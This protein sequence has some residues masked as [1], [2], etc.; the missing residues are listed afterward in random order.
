[1][2]RHR[3]RVIGLIMIGILTAGALVGGGWWLGQRSQTQSAAS[4]VTTAPSAGPPA[5]DTTTPATPTSPADAGTWQR[6]PAAPI[7]GGS[8]AGVWTGTELL[9]HAP[10]FDHQN[11]SYI[12][13]SVGAAY[14]PATHSWRNLPPAP[15]PVES[16]EGGYRAVW[17][18]R[19]LLGW[20]MGL[21][22]AYNPATNRWRKIATGGSAWAVMAWTG[23]QVLTWGGGCCGDD[24]AGGAAYNPSTDSWSR[25]PAGPLAGRQQTTG[26][27]TGTELVVV[28]G[29]NVDA[30]VFG[31]AAAYN[32]ATR[33]WRRLPALPEPRTG[34]T[35][36]WNGRE[37]LVVGGQGRF[38]DRARPYADGV[39]YSPASNRWRRLPAMDTGRIG[40]TA[41][42][43]GRQLLVWGGRTRDAGSW[44]APAHGLAYDRA[45][46]R[47]SPL[48]KS[49]LRGRAGHIAVWTGSQMLVW[50]GTPA[51]AS[52]PQKPFADGAAYTPYPL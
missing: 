20:G 48:P 40:H 16:I 52:D 38:S 15:G 26:T 3:Q 37:V 34:A 33:S 4:G 7:P 5:A 49:P 41:V 28:G 44:T 31:D 32:P 9:L 18:G 27:W 10:Y 13:R 6:L 51:R 24:V 39:A 46:D 45:S 36:T 25:L 47:W 29:N 43:T 1:M 19:E 42:C 35:V 50:G 12:G 23:R 2:N 30:K 22:A 14:N 8:Y 21:D 17:T 11:G